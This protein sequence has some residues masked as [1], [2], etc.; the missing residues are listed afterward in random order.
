MSLLSWALRHGIGPAALNELQHELGLLTPAL[1]VD[2]PAYG[3]SEAFVQSGARLEASRRGIRA[4]RNNVG[5]LTDENGR[6]VRYGLANESGAVNDAV[7]SSDLIGWRRVVIEPRMVG[8]T[9]AQFWAREVKAPGWQFTGK[10]REVQQKA[11]I[12]MVNAEGGDGAFLTD[13]GQV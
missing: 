1:P 9:V 8:Y 6:L 2:A 7:K 11:F 10:G 3:K 4:F 12:D 13:P 5:A